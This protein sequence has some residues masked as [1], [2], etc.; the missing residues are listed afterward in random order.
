[1]FERFTKSARRTVEAA[2]VDAVGSG[3]DRVRPDHLLVG[4]LGEADGLAVQ[5]LARLGAPADRLLDELAGRRGR[6]VDGL[7]D[8]DAAALATIGIDLEEVLSRIG[9]APAPRPGRRHVRFSPEAKKVLEL[10]LREAVSLQHGRIGTE[11]IL[12]GLVRGGDPRVIDS[13][14]AL[15]VAPT[16]LRA[17]VA[18][19]VRQAG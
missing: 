13:L 11:H 17:A 8:E 2:V 5:V 7:G 3:S 15:G 1:M 9:E 4:V 12:L 6:T 14:A 10:S 18:D 16:A 19:A